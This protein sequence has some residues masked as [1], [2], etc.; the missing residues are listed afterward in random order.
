MSLVNKPLDDWM[1]Y[2]GIPCF[3]YSKRKKKLI[4]KL[5]TENIV[6]D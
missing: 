5:K 3:A 6:T 4:G 2:I 1:I